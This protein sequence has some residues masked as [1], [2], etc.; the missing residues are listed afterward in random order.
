M[1]AAAARAGSRSPMRSISISGRLATAPCLRVLRPT[2]RSCA[3]RRR[4]GR[5]RGRAASNRAALPARSAAADRVARRL[6]SGRQTEQAQRA[7]AVMRE[8]GMQADPAA[9][10][11]PPRRGS[12]P[13]TGSQSTGVAAI[14]GESAAALERRLAH[15]DRNRLRRDRREAVRSRLPRARPNRA[16]PEPQCRRANDEG[17]HT[18][19]AHCSSRRPSALSGSPSAVHSSRTSRAAPSIMRSSVPEGRAACLRR[20][21]RPGSDNRMNAESERRCRALASGGPLAADRIS[22]ILAGLGAARRD[23]RARSRDHPVVIVCGETGS[24]KTTQLPKIALALGRGRA[25]TAAA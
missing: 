22:R 24:G 10:A 14:D 6:R 13:A 5:R 1:R 19:P 8:V 16:S 25:P 4:P 17:R 18:A 12:R 7:V 11:P 15:V 23:R 20:A 9:A 21:D 2:R 3:A